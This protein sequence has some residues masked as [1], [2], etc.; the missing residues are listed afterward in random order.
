MGSAQQ[1]LTRTTIR[2]SHRPNP[3]RPPSAPNYRRACPHGRGV[4]SKPTIHPTIHPTN[5]RKQ[6]STGY[7]DL[8]SEKTVTP[9]RQTHTDATPLAEHHTYR[10]AYILPAKTTDGRGD[11]IPAPPLLGSQQKPNNNND[12]HV[13]IAVSHPPPVSRRLLKNRSPV[14]GTH[15]SNSK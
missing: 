3:N 7:I 12:A 1:R 6:Q 11:I 2:A 14:L 13:H 9:T 4:F 15:H 8:P 5:Q 10:P